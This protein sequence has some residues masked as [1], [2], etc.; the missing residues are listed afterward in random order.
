MVADNNGQYTYDSILTVASVL[1][2]AASELELVDSSNNSSAESST[3]FF[4]DSGADPRS[5]GFLAWVF[6]NLHVSSQ[7]AKVVKI[8]FKVIFGSTKIA[9]LHNLQL[10]YL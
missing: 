2:F 3:D 6:R 5:V 10:N 9:S 8:K 1:G 7:A 4:A